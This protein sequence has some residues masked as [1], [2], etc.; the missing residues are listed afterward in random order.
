MIM[1]T[2]GDFFVENVFEELD[3]PGEF[4]HNETSGELFLYHNGTG[5]P[6]A[7]AV[8]VA[9]QTQVLFNLSGSQWAPVRDV[10][11]SGLKFTAA[12]YTYMEPHG[13]PS[14]GDWALERFGAVF[15]QGTE[16]VQITGCVFDRFVRCVGVCFCLCV[17]FLFAFVCALCFC[18]CFLFVRCVCFLFMHLFL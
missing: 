18:V 15:L 3:N 12:A 2:G 5:A 14:A 6:A 11:I 7:D 1:H 10:R 9:P 17:A 13:V 16:G 4:F 8:V